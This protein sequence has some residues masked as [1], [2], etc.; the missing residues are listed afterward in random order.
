MKE[1]VA[2]P[3]GK[4]PEIKRAVPTSDPGA[5]EGPSFLMRTWE[6]V[7]T[8]WRELSGAEAPLA[9]RSDLGARERTDLKNRM[10]ACLDGRGGEVSA[11]QR[12]AGLGQI[13]LDL[14]RAGRLEF[15][16]VLAANF[17]PERDAVDA[18]VIEYE[19]ADDEAAR[20]SA[21][22][23]LRRAL[24]A[25]RIELLTQFNALPQGVKFLVDM[26]ADVLAFLKEA[27]ELEPLERDL[28]GLLR[29]WFDV[30]FLE[31][32]AINWQSPAALLEKLIEYEAVHEIRSWQ[33][34]HNRL[35]ADR[36]L[37]AFFH[38]NMPMEPLIFVEV[39]LVRGL[40]DN[41]QTLLDEDAPTADPRQQDAAIFYSISN[42]QNGLRGISL[43]NFLIKRVVEDLR[44]ELPN[45][46]TFSTLS[47]V[48]GFRKWMERAIADGAP[49]ILTAEDRKRLKQ[50][51]G[52]T[53]AKGHLPKLIAEEAWTE[54]P[55][56]VEAL[57]EPLMRL[58]ARYLVREKKG[59]GPRD[60]VARFH[61]SNGAQVERINWMGDVSEKGL[62]QSC[63]MMVNYLYKLSDIER[64]HERFAEEGHIAVSS[65]VKALL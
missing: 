12:A 4:A 5:G 60:P 23:R 9:G 64:N 61:L 33:D 28:K 26:R 62:Q 50:A 3:E 31:M 51:T 18:A 56:L 54:E 10:A 8:A 45:L 42:T 13:Y 14:G 7:R 25:P 46:K 29:S 15:L 34:L 6:S 32:Q 65:Q 24:T 55:A 35:A 49:R 48:P 1:T 39:A 57:R 40:A 47:P 27:P 63:G 16:K 22:D 11:R 30:G 44:H 21:Q 41:V 59:D 36:R 38:P 20:R 58:C 53:V 52:R 37:Y 17:G 43:G 2:M 19:A